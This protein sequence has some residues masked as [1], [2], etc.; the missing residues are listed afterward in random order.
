MMYWGRSSSNRTTVFSFW[1]T[2]C[3]FQKGAILVRECNM[4]GAQAEA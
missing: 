3:L 1:P 2:D 4:E